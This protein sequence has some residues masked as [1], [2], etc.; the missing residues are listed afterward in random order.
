M[1]IISRYIIK[2]LISNLLLGI[3]VL[4]SVFLTVDF[5]GGIWEFLDKGI[6]LSVMIDYLINKIPWVMYNMIPIACLMATLLTISEL[7]K[8]NEIIAMYAGGISIWKIAS[9]VCFIG[10]ALTIFSFALNEYLVPPTFSKAKYIRAVKVKNSK[11]QAFKKNKIWYRGKNII[12]NLQY[13]EPSEKIINGITIYFFNDKFKIAKQITANTAKWIKN[14]WTFYEGTIIDFE[15]SNYPKIRTF[16]EEIIYLP[17][18]PEDLTVIEKSTDTVSFRELREYVEKSKRAGLKSKSFEVDMHS[19]VAIP[20]SC[21]I[22]ML[23]AIPFALKHQRKG[24]VAVNLGYTF[25]FVLSYLFIQAISVSYGHSGQIP[26]VL[27]AWITNIIF[28]SFSVFMIS[29]VRS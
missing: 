27:A 18:K 26:P 7:S 29:K 20:F 22:M 9:I 15:Q 19:K 5:L 14:N 16:S 13:F 11:Y 28:I 21:L 24:G 3:F 2:E 23:L 4:T 6:P 1:G 8:N 17:E 12:Y 10:I 25:L